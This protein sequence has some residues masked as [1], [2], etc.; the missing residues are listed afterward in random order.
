VVDDDALIEGHERMVAAI[1]GLERRGH[2]LIRRGRRR[3]GRV[4]SRRTLARAR[5]DLVL[6]GDRPISAAWLGWW[7]GARSMV[8]AVPEARRARWSFVERWCWRSL[9]AWALE[10]RAETESDAT[11]AAD[12]DAEPERVIAWPR[13]DDA[14]DGGETDT[15]ALERGCEHILA[16]ARSGGARPAVFLDRDGTLVVEKGY[17]S[18]AAAMELLPGVP[19]ALRN[20]RAAGFAIV[21]ISNQA[22]VGRGLFPIASVHEAMGALRRDLRAHG[23]EIDAIYF[24]P[25]RPDEGCDCRKP[26][27]GLLRRAARDLR[28]SLA[29]SVM[30]GDKGIDVGAARAAGALG[31]LVRTG[32]GREEEVGAAAEAARSG[33]ILH[34]ADDLAAAARGLL[35]RDH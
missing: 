19:E 2:D 5:V 34:V 23:V 1:A 17:G 25:H 27:P 15:D 12:A 3:G 30:I 22:G 32:Y 24:C 18:G 21:V 10:E 29:D 4:P 26:M 8:L 20:L 35:S 9:D 33:S 7:S 28:L 31:I 14:R 13:V 16:R 11:R 6:G